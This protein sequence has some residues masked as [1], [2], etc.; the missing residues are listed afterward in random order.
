MNIHIVALAQSTLI[1]DM[2]IPQTL[3]R[4]QQSC[5]F[6]YFKHKLVGWVIDKFLLVQFASKSYP[7]SLPDP[8]P[9]EYNIHQDAGQWFRTS[10]IRKFLIGVELYCLFSRDLFWNTKRFT[11]LYGSFPN[12]AKWWIGHKSKYSYS[13]FKINIM[14]SIFWGFF[15]TYYR[16]TVS[17]FEL[18]RLNTWT[19]RA[20][21]RTV[22]QTRVIILS[23]S[24]TL[25]SARFVRLWGKIEL[26]D[27]LARAHAMLITLSTHKSRLIPWSRRDADC[28]QFCSN[29]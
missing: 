7:E 24:H 4:S 15:L 25:R 11:N 1:L 26:E 16:S 22:P 23:L 5:D 8:P 18:R 13:H 19:V 29:E 17:R 10:S 6:H 3:S 27:D 28:L 2:Y 14:R 20:L 9:S 12:T 21:Q